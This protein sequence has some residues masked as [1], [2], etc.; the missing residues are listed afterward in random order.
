MVLNHVTIARTSLRISWKDSNECAWHS[1]QTN[2][3]RGPNLEDQIN[4]KPWDRIFDHRTEKMTLYQDSKYLNKSTLALS[5][6]SAHSFRIPSLRP[7]RE[8]IENQLLLLARL[9]K[10][11]SYSS[12]FLLWKT[13]LSVAKEK[14]KVIEGSVNR[15]LFH[16][17]PDREISLVQIKGALLSMLIPHSIQFNSIIYYSKVKKFTIKDFSRETF[18]LGVFFRSK[19]FFKNC[20]PYCIG[21]PN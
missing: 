5:L 11:C 17:S 6:V 3:A 12:D 21:G 7:Q 14:R 4:R 13:K 16:F 1:A 8:R 9:G 15:G 10:F 2:W 20:G 18:S 19:D